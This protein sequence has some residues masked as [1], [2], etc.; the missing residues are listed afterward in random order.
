MELS[1]SPPPTPAD[2]Y[3]VYRADDRDAVIAEGLEAFH[4]IGQ[5]PDLTFLDT[6]SSIESEEPRGI[7]Y[8]TAIVGDE[9][10]APS[11]PADAQYPHCWNVSTPEDCFIP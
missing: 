10:S 2:V 6:S 1:W 3:I 7:Y 4:A 5:T 11:N 9:E 8:V